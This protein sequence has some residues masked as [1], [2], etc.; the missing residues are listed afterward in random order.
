MKRQ[1][2]AA[3]DAIITKIITNNKQPKRSTT[4]YAYG[5]NRRIP[6]AFQPLIEEYFDLSALAGINKTS[7]PA[8]A[9]DRIDKEL[10]K[11]ATRLRWKI[12]HDKHF[13]L[14]DEHGLNY[15]VYSDLF[16]YMVRLKKTHAPNPKK[17]K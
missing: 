9:L 10:I 5:R 6:I 2:Q 16:P 12:V 15:K 17:K 13:D 1:T 3:A 4:V 11:I 8:A 14:V 7:V